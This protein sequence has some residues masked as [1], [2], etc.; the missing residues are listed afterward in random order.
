MRHIKRLVILTRLAALMREMQI[1]VAGGAIIDAQKIAAVVGCPG[2]HIK[3]AT[4]VE[5]VGR[6]G[7]RC[8]TVTKHNFAVGIQF[9]LL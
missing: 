6:Q 7:T 5:V 8:G 9:K 1:I 2:V 4:T 3:M